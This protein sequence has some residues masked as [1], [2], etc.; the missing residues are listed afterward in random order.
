MIRVHGVDAV[1]RKDGTPYSTETD[2]LYDPDAPDWWQF[3]TRPCYDDEE[4]DDDDE[5]NED[6]Y[7]DDY[8]DGTKKLKKAAKDGFMMG[9]GFGIV[10]SVINGGK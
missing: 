5:Y 6:D 3:D 9:V 7:D 8:D 4:D 2:N 10:N 1:I